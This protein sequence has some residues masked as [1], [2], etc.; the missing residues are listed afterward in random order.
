MNLRLFYLQN[1]SV[2]RVSSSIPSGGPNNLI[3]VQF[4]L[5]DQLSLFSGSSQ[6]SKLIY[7]RL[8]CV[9]SCLWDGRKE[10]L[11][12][13]THSTHLIIYGWLYGVRH[14]VK[15]HS[16]SKRGNPLLPHGLLFLISSKGSF[17]CIIPQSHI[18]ITS[19]LSL[20]S[21]KQTLAQ[22]KSQEFIGYIK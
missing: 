1:V 10:M 6:C 19:H 22:I 12:L 21:I 2:V 18:F 9:L 4:L 11:Y 16:D 13:T 15:D 5:V 14:M 3:L 20:V 17:I 7:Q 8:R